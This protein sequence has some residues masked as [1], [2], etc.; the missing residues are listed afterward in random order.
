MT[1]SK[2][3][4]TGSVN[5][6][7]VHQKQMC[8]QSERQD[9]LVPQLQLQFWRQCTDQ[10]SYRY[11][12]WMIWPSWPR[13]TVV[14]LY[15][16]TKSKA[17]WLYNS[18]ISLGRGLCS[19]SERSLVKSAHLLTGL[20]LHSVWVSASTGD[21]MLK[22]FKKYSH[23]YWRLSKTVFC[24]IIRKSKAKTKFQSSTIFRYFEAEALNLN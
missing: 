20:C 10:C 19:I 2:T 9:K 12:C 14:S 3:D 23:G 15:T 17:R 18:V 16:Q 24:Y 7:Y 22:M 13:W 21:Y 1:S 8:W 5:V 4:L 6:S 11:S